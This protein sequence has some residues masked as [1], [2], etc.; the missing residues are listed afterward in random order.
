MQ[1]GE[2]FRHRLDDDVCG[3]EQAVGL[4]RLPRRAQQ[5]WT[6]RGEVV[7]R[8]GMQGHTVTPSPSARVRARALSQGLSLLT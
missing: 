4:L 8:E 6:R 5:I 3:V 1:F 2:P 7:F